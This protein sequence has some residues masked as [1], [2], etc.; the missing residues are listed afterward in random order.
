MRYRIDYQCGRLR[1]IKCNSSATVNR[2]KS[3]HYKRLISHVVRRK[4]VV[5]RG[6]L[7]ND[8]RS[9]DGRWRIDRLWISGHRKR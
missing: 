5:D 4:L 1:R 8:R 2:W 3:G 9:Y 6:D 7:P